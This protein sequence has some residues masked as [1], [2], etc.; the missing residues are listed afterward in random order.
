MIV[1]WNKYDNVCICVW[2]LAL[3]KRRVRRIVYCLL[4]VFVVYWSFKLDFKIKN[5]SIN[6]LFVSIC[7]SHCILNL[8]SPSIIPKILSLWFFLI[9]L[10]DI[11]FVFFTLCTVFALC[12]R[13]RHQLF[14]LGDLPSDLTSPL[15]HNLEFFYDKLNK[16][17]TF[18]KEMIYI[19]SVIFILR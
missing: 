11:F 5:A 15:S 19:S 13:N 14:F 1:R 9:F 3:G 2:L 16:H 6:G 18:W 10:I 8:Q 7:L 4:F 12:R 17:V